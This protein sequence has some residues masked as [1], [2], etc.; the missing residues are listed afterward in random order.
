MSINDINGNMPLFSETVA[1]GGLHVHLGELAELEV[2]LERAGES[3][4]DEVLA[5]LH[6]EGSVRT[7]RESELSTL[8]FYPK[9]MTANF[10]RVL[11]TL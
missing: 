11:V 4:Q 1:P 9:V 2:H 6:R 3:H 5:L 8:P 7:V 10:Q